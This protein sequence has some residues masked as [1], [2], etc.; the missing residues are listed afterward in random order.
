VSEDPAGD[1]NNPNLYSY[2]GNNPLT[3]ID[4]TGEGWVSDTWS[5]I[6]SF[7]SSLFGGEN[8][9]TGSIGG[10]PDVTPPPGSSSSESESDENDD[11]EGKKEN[12]YVVDY[13]VQKQIQ[14]DRR[15]LLDKVKEEL[16]KAENAELGSEEWSQAMDNM[17][18][19]FEEIGILNGK[20][21]Y[22]MA[23]INLESARKTRR[24]NPG[25]WKDA[26]EWYNQALDN[27]L[28]LAGYD[29]YNHK[30]FYYKRGRYIHVN[31]NPDVVITIA[32]LGDKLGAASVK[33]TEGYRTEWE[34]YNV[35]YK[36]VKEPKDYS[37][38][39]HGKDKAADVT[40]YDEN[41]QP[42]SAQTAYNAAYNM[43]EIGG[44]GTY[45]E[46]GYSIIHMDLRSRKSDGTPSTW[47]GL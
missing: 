5:A 25:K 28:D 24:A 45:L 35:V 42:I 43:P 39:Q 6:T 2:T 30:N 15:Q 16:D 26:K 20:E 21:E 33:I 11:I 12:V 3:R 47:Q 8:S 9:N 27:L 36:D 32:E 14:M 40:F 22:N 13:D 29:Q 23:A 1:P 7:F 34:H 37:F 38:N 10:R 44:L 46:E 31:S 19:Y 17:A 18:K 4:P 41:G